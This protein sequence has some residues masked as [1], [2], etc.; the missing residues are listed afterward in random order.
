MNERILGIEEKISNME[1]RV[2]NIDKRV[3][4]LEGDS[5]KG[6]STSSEHA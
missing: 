3:M 5:N 2:M 4:S 1:G 6:G